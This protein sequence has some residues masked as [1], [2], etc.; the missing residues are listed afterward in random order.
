MTSILKILKALGDPTRVRILLLLE[1]HSLTV[2]E[3]QEILSMGQSRISTQ[4]AQLKQA[5]LVDDRRSGKN[6]FYTL[7]S[8]AESNATI[9]Q[10]LDAARDEIDE[11]T[12]DEAALRFVLEKRRDKIRAHF[13]ELAGRFGRDFVPGRSWKSLCEAMLKLLPPMVIADLGAGEG[14]LSQLLAQRAE[15]VFAIDNSEKMVAYGKKIAEEHGLV[16][17]EYRLGDIEQI[18]I[19]DA[20]VD[21]AVFSQAL[22]HAEKPERAIREAYRIVRPGGRIVILDLVQHNFEEARELYADTWLGFPEVELRQWLEQAGFTSVESSIV[23]R[24]DEP[25]N[26]QTMLALGQKSQSGK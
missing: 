1:A 24:S 8:D 11:W 14:T 21:L 10:L 3:M 7:H 9:R 5:R 20:S 18:P 4:L 15:H 12:K 13:D 6:N 25:P 23:D 17:L 22:H 16:N 26:F 2:A 19:D